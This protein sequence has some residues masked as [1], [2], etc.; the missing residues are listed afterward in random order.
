[1]TTIVIGGGISG[2]IYCFYHPEAILVRERNVS[3]G[4][5]NPFVYI[6]ENSYTKKLLKD[7]CYEC[8]IVDVNVEN[9]TSQDTI[10]KSKLGFA[11][12]KEYTGTNV[13]GNVRRNN[14]LSVYHIGQN[15]L[16]S[17]MENTLSNRIVEGK[18]TNIL[19]DRIYID[20]Q[21]YKSVLEYDKI[22]S[23]IHF[24]QFASICSWD[25]GTSVKTADVYYRLDFGKANKNRMVYVE[26]DD[27]YALKGVVKIFENKIVDCIGYELKGPSSDGDYLVIKDGRVYGS[28][29]PAPSN[30]LFLGR[31]ATGNSHWRIEDS[32]F[33]ADGGV[34]IAEIIEEQKRYDYALKSKLGLD[35]DDRVN[36]IILHIHSELSELL[37]EVNWKMNLKSK[38]IPKAT[39]ILE[40]I[41]DI[42]KLALAVAYEYDY[43]PREIVEKFWNKSEV[44][45]KTFIEEFYGGV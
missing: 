33:V 2:L 11:V 27:E 24:K 4:K 34:M 21:E 26:E 14:I 38:K 30:V 7:L 31:F 18:V 41:I 40:E 37:R 9:N 29:A 44:N 17:I 43:T 8:P 35:K 15:N 10:L 13:I 36:K 1:M 23:T 25:Y 32:I 5:E 39:S 45:W 20:Q 3:V 28:I 16:C 42:I 6:Q 19:A 22:I 12:K